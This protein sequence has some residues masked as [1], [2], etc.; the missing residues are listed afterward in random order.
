MSAVGVSSSGGGF[1]SQRPAAGAASPC[2]GCIQHLRLATRLQAQLEDATAEVRRLKAMLGTAASAAAKGGVT[3]SASSVSAASTASTVSGCR[4]LSY[5]SSVGTT[6]SLR[7]PLATPTLEDIAAADLRSAGGSAW[8]GWSASTGA[9]SP[10]PACTTRVRRAAFPNSP[11]STD[12]VLNLIPTLQRADSPAPAA[13]LA[14]PS[15]CSLTFSLGSNDGACCTPAAS[16]AAP[17]PSSRRQV[18]RGSGQRDVLEGPGV[19][20]RQAAANAAWP[21]S[22]LFPPAACGAGAVA[23]TGAM[24][25]GPPASG[26]D[27]APRLE[28]ADRQ[29][30]AQQ[31]QPSEQRD[32]ADGRAADETDAVAVK[33]DR[34]P[35]PKR[36]WTRRGREEALSKVAQQ[37]Q[38]LQTTVIA[39]LKSRLS[40]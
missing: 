12:P 39:P 33:D 5:G 7:R 10:S 15:N 19:G 29:G 24:E 8:M 11:P 21:T 36:V 26:V 18:V 32:T 6:S 38:Q 37:L 13:E 9:G 28:Q 25:A 22:V 35:V 16:T 14:S 23:G 2:P 17:Q 27:A 4:D 31:A 40:K 30:G 20:R 1:R 3:P 34:D